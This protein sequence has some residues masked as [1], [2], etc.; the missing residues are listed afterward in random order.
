MDVAAI[1]AAIPAYRPAARRSWTGWRAAAAIAL[2]AAGGTSVAVMQ[3]S[4]SIARDTLLT[5]SAPVTVGV[6]SP[7]ASMALGTTRNVGDPSVPAVQQLAPRELALGSTAVGELSDGELSALLAD[8]ES[9]EAL[10]SADAE[11]LPVSPVAP[12]GTD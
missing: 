9:I 5:M 6:D 2:L 7:V 3:R 11:P 12:K 8:L 1:A 4:G 10:P